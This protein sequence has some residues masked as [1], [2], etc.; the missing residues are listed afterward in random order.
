MRAAAKTLLTAAAVGLLAGLADAQARSAAVL[1]LRDPSG[2]P[3]ADAD[4]MLLLGP[5]RDLPA[6][7]GV[8][9]PGG[10]AVDP[11]YAPHLLRAR[12]DARGEL[13]FPADAAPRAGAAVVLAGEGLG[14]VV[15]WLRPG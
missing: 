7:R 13:R 11:T 15:P 9:F 14:T 8:A 4:G 10:A 2:A 3:V 5:A 1:L 6:L 12:S